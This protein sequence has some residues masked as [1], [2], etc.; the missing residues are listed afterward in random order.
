MPRCPSC[1][2]PMTRLEEE[3]IPNCICQQCFGRWMTS[4]AIH[5]RTRLDADLAT[6]ATAGGENPSPLMQESLQDLVEIAAASNSKQPLR[7]P[8]C[9]KPMAKERFHQMIPVQVD[10]CARCK[11]LWFDAGEYALIRRLYVEMLIST[12]PRIVAMREKI[13]GARLE[14]DARTRLLDQAREAID[15]GLHQPATDEFTVA[16]LA[17]VL[18]GAVDS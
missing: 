12:D 10:R 1:F 15:R 3:G 6:P 13:A 14:W 18:R 7:C 9:E 2:L 4:I 17:R 8:T 16:E 11:S 5:R